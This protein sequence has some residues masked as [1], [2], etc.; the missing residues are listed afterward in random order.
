MS[1]TSSWSISLLLNLKRFYIFFGVS[2]VDLKQQMPALE[3]KLSEI[4]LIP[5]NL[6]LGT[7]NIS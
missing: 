7:L 2:I 3:L 5:Q 6:H 4:R 1:V